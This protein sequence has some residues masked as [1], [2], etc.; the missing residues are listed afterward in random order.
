MYIIVRKYTNF[1]DW[2]EAEDWDTLLPEYWW[3]RWTVL[4]Y[5]RAWT[6]SNQEIF[7]P[8]PLLT[9][10]LLSFRNGYVSRH[11]RILKR[12]HKNGSETS[13][14]KMMLSDNGTNLIAGDREIRE[15]VAQIDKDKIQRSSANKGVDWHWNPAAAPHF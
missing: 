4:D 15:L 10:S 3:Y 8:F 12:F 13:W 6:S 2:I 1:Q 7:V 11:S 5:P 9:F 14:P